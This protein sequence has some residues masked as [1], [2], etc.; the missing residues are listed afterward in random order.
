[1]THC[2]IL[3]FWAVQFRPFFVIIYSHS[4][5]ILSNNLTPWLD[6]CCSDIKPFL[7]Q[8][9]WQ[10]IGNIYKIEVKTVI[11]RAEKGEKTR[12]KPH[13]LGFFKIPPSPPYD[14]IRAE[15]LLFLSLFRGF[16]PFSEHTQ[17]EYWQNIGKML[18]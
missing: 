11:K 17:I 16:S 10:N 12:I 6:C 13:I 9:Y 15:R 4:W 8:K 7:L 5:I 14:R 1:M 3:S 18:K 2:L